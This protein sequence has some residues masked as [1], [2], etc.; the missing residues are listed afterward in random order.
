VKLGTNL[1]IPDS[2]SVAP[3]IKLVLP[4][5]AVL[6]DDEITAVTAGGTAGAPC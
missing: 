4:V 6:R 1:V 5:V 2:K 3:P